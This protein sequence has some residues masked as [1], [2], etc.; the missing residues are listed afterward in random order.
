MAIIDRTLLV[1]PFTALDQ[2]QRHKI[3]AEALDELK[4]DESLKIDG[5]V[6]PELKKIDADGYDWDGREIVQSKQR[7]SF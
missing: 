6:E 4:K 2:T 7:S 1:V 5:G 3:R